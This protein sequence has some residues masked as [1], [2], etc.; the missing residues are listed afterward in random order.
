[1]IRRWLAAAATLAMLG[2]T[3]TA[4]AMPGGDG[5][6]GTGPYPQ[7]AVAAGGGTAGSIW[8]YVVIAAVVVFGVTLAGARLIRRSD[9]RRR[10]A[11][12]AR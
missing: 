5:A 8:W 4:S 3:A 11:G 6:G 1:M 10:L 12:A 9:Q 7:D 2:V